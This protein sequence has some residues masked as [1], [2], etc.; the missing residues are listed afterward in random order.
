MHLS[1]STTNAPPL[2]AYLIIAVS[3]ASSHLSFVVPIC[4]FLFS[5][6]PVVSLLRLVLFPS[7]QLVVDFE[8]SWIQPFSSTLHFLS[9]S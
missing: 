9:L 2:L 4:F 6:F 8:L 7:F 1:L 3:T 5:F